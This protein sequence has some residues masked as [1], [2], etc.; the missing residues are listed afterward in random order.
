MRTYLYTSIHLPSGRVFA[1]SSR[2]ENLKA[3]Y[4]HLIAWNNSNPKVWL[5][6][7]TGDAS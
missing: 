6:A 7:P 5:F 4:G 1:G 3:F 2:C